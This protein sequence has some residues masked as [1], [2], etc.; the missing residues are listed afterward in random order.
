M[1]CTPESHTGKIRRRSANVSVDWYRSM[2]LFNIVDRSSL[3]F[4]PFPFISERLRGR[5]VILI[6]SVGSEGAQALRRV[7]S[8]SLIDKLK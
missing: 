1:L 7:T 4:L 5:R 6:I 3:P 8:F 2:P